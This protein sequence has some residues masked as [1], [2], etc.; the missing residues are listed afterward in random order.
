[1][2]WIK[3]NVLNISLYLKRVFGLLR[4][5]AMADVY[6]IGQGKE[7]IIRKGSPF[8]FEMHVADRYYEF[9]NQDYGSLVKMN[10]YFVIVLSLGLSLVLKSVFGFS[11]LYEYYISL[12]AF[13]LS[14]VFA[15]LFVY[16]MM[17]K[18]S[19]APVDEEEY[20]NA[21]E[22]LHFI[23]EKSRRPMPKWLLAITFVGV[24]IEAIA[25][26]IVIISW[27]ANTTRTI[28]LYFGIALGAAVAATIALTVHHAGEA[29][30][31]EHHR[32]VMWSAIDHESKDNQ[33][34]ERRLIIRELKKIN[35]S[36]T[37]KKHGFI[38]T[39]GPMVW[40]VMMIMLLA[41]FAF[42]SRA[43]LNLG[44]INSRMQVQQVDD[45]AFFASSAPADVVNSPEVA[46][47]N[48]SQVMEQTEIN[49]MYAS[50]LAL[51]IIFLI[52]NYMGGLSGYKYSF[53][54]DTSEQSFKLI[55]RFEKQQAKKGKKKEGVTAMQKIVEEKAN[56]LFSYY[57]PLLI[58]TISTEDLRDS[59]K[60]SLNERGVY[61][62][63]S[64]IDNKELHQS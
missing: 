18:R 35:P 4:K 28:E 3:W 39:Y 21:K 29:L 37:F 48:N 43:N 19:E 17:M 34:A 20:K 53:Y 58:N 32:K 42:F 52:I 10:I 55:R 63:K 24:L 6:E 62:M 26:I 45:S 2:N 46:E 12:V 57:Y 7:E 64:Y 5:K 22:W 1:M 11:F 9:W 25:I 14:S 40:A 23:C 33:D 38:R 31:K 41:V 13:M 27:F 61:R 50:L 54:N 60:V 47:S 44:I 16:E 30:Y 15:G 51:M 56:Q 59:L 36:I 8:G 49:S